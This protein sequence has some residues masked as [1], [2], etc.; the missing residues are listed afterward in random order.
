MNIA[1]IEKQLE[2]WTKKTN[3][4][5]DEAR[6]FYSLLHKLGIPKADA[7]RDFDLANTNTF[8]LNEIQ[9]K[10]VIDFIDNLYDRK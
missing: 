10:E 1:K 7:T 2:V 3:E 6:H 8:H 9:T 4:R 5:L